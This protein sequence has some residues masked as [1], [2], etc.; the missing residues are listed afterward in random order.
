MQI[1]QI[2][3]KSEK[4]KSLL[5]ELFTHLFQKDSISPLIVGLSRNRKNGPTYPESFWLNL[6]GKF[7][8]NSVVPLIKGPTQWEYVV[9]SNYN[10]F[11]NKKQFLKKDYILPIMSH[12]NREKYKLSF[13]LSSEKNKTKHFHDSVTRILLRRHCHEGTYKL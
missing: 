8:E 7:K 9:T 6:I 12:R 10:L 2:D 3:K 11:R 1:Q 13:L 5:F 4:F